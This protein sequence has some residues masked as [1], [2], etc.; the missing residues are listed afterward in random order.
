MLS[1]C[2]VHYHENKMFVNPALIKMGLSSC[3]IGAYLGLLIDAQSFGG[4]PQDINNTPIKYSLCRLIIGFI[5]VSPLTLP[6]FLL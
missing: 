3:P 2:G 6:Y 5:L 1:K 4:T